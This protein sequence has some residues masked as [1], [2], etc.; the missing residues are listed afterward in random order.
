MD[1]RLKGFLAATMAVSVVA[2]A[3]SPVWARD[4][5]A[6]IH[7][8]LSLSANQSD[9]SLLD[10]VREAIEAHPEFTS[11]IVDAAVLLQPDLAEDIRLAAAISGEIEVA[12]AAGPLGLAFAPLLA[13]A[14][15]AGAAAAVAGAGG[16]GGGDD[17]DTVDSAPPIEAPPVSGPQPPGPPQAPNAF[18]TTEYFASNGLS[19]L[20]ASDA[21]GRGL[22]GAGVIVAVVD[23]GLDI[24][25]S[26]FLGRVAPGGF[27]FLNNNTDVT[28]LNGHGT[29]V[30]GI[31]AANKDGAGMHGLAY[32]ASLLA[33]QIGDATSF[34]STSAGLAAATDYAVTSGA[35]VLNNSWGI[36][37]TRVTELTTPEI[38]SAIG[39]EIEAYRR[40]AAADRVIVFAAHNAGLVD[41]SPRAGLPYH[42]PE[43]QPYWLAVVA[44]D[45]S[46]SIASYSN[47]C[48]VAAPWCLAAPGNNIISAAPGG[49]YAAKSGTSMAAPHVTA[50]VA[51]LKQLFPELSAD[52]IVERLLVTANS[53]GIYANQAIYGQ[54]LLDLETATRPV[55]ATEVLTG[56]TIAGA[57]FQLSNT[58]V[59]LGAAFGDGLKNAL[60]GVKLAIFDS[61]RATFFVDLAP[62]VQIADSSI[63]L[64]G[65][66]KRFG[67]VE[68]KEFV[69]GQAKITMALTSTNSGAG[70]LTH[71]T[72]EEFSFTS[73]VDENLSLSLSY[74]TDP[75]LGFGL[76]GSGAVDRTM[77]ITQSAF[78]APYLSMTDDTFSFGTSSKLAGLGDI[79][80]MSF[81]GNIEA[82]GKGFG[83]ATEL[84]AQPVEA[85]KIAVQFGVVAEETTFLG[86]GTQGAFG[87]AGTTPTL[88]SGLSGEVALNDKLS[89]VGSIYTGV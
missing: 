24:N 50:A 63:D 17:G 9:D 44:T 81:A 57:T 82:G 84:A 1:R 15:A 55:G 46:G 64:P 58:A 3:L 79:R 41:P 65:L 86:T 85:A 47:R 48:G 31:I 59:Q 83:T 10:A 7:L 75:A 34:L 18:E 56:A 87:F 80:V 74:A 49:G 68:T 53:S 30:A 28:D 70:E 66:L 35:F 78:A 69:F 43:L 23:T 88:F 61:Q 26:E 51:V 33:V 2:S 13:G 11:E 19:A 38:F 62:F 54:G 72:L 8:T 29:H 16:G 27:N 60:S 5:P 32:G 21:Y 77:F 6:N 25:H 40:A 67:A 73:R 71:D 12:P 37:G 14:G 36:L 42:V 76:H 22:T 52:V 4:L 45:Q 39:P 89:L 20:N